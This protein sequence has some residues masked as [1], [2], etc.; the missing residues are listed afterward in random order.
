MA[1][2]R[3]TDTGLGDTVFIKFALKLIHKCNWHKYYEQENPLRSIYQLAKCF[4][5][6]QFFNICQRKAPKFGL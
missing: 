5:I 6:H 4:W 1:F 3:L 2:F